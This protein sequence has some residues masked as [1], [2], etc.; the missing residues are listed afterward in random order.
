MA[1]RLSNSDCHIRQFQQ[2]ALH[3]VPPLDGMHRNLCNE[4]SYVVT[5][6]NRVALQ[7]LGF[8]LPRQ[9]AILALFASG[10]TF[11]TKV[12]HRRGRGEDGSSDERPLPPLTYVYLN[13]DGDYLR[14][15]RLLTIPVPENTS[16]EKLKKIEVAKAKLEAFVNQQT[17]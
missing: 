12:G 9:T 16:G 7:Y 1:L 11:F 17:L 8:T 6:L 10:Y 14:T 15:L 13:M 5:T 2:L 4:V 3:L